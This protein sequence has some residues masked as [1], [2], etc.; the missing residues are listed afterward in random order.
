M[1]ELG[2]QTIPVASISLGLRLR[3]VDEVH[4]QHLAENIQEIGRLRSPIE[5]RKAKGRKGDSYTIVAGGHRFRAIQLLGWTEVPAFVFEMTDQEARIWEI[6]ENIQQMLEAFWD[7]A[8]KDHRHAQSFKGIY[9]AITGDHQV[10]G[11]LSNCD[12]ALMREALSAGTFDDVLG[13]SITRRMIADYNAP[14]I[15]DGWRQFANVVPVADFRTQ[16]RTRWGGY[17]DLPAVA[18]R[19]NYDPLT[20]P[21]DEKASYGIT[22]RGGTESISIEMIA[23]DDVGVIRQIPVKL[24]RAAKRGLAKFVFDFVKNNAVIYDGVA[25]YHASHGNLLSGALD[26][27]SYAAARLAHMKQTEPGSGERLG[28]GPHCLLVAQDLEEGAADIFRRNTE[29]DKTFIQSLTP[30]IIPVWYWTDANDWATVAD[31]M[32]MPFIEIGFWNGQQEPELFIQDSP[33][34]GSLFNNDTITYKI[35]FVYGGVVVDFRAS[36]KSVVA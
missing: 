21:A 20:S 13:N 33:N 4:A 15:Y 27:A 18:E 28:I 26:K 2:L 30:T 23:N 16:E 12:Q 3:V 31:P 32:E 5:V 25:L 22:K 6:D 19:G 1:K 8:H 29:N 36:V 24:S 7:P 10:T 11:R 14:S 34:Q 17:G 35:R 9:V